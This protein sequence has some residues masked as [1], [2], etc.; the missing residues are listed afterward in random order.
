MSKTSFMIILLSM[1]T[2]A[3]AASR[4]Y[5]NPFI[6]F[7]SIQ[8]NNY[9]KNIKENEK[10]KSFMSEGAKQADSYVVTM[11][12]EQGVSFPKMHLF[13]LN[14]DGKIDLVKH[15]EK[16]VLVKMEV[17]TDYDNHPDYVLFY[18]NESGQLEMKVVAEN[19]TNIWSHY[20]KNELRRKD[21]DRDNDQKPDMWQYFRN[22]RMLKTEVSKNGSSKKEDI[23]T[24]VADEV[25][26]K[27]SKKKK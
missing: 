13:D 1:F 22:G 21:F 15:F 16:K 6:N 10:L 9:L 27:N 14:G 12:D 8:L 5:S 11:T 18:N 3:I 17:D 4:S 19:Q 23:T 20:Y 7:K 26:K 25:V 24:S 2:S